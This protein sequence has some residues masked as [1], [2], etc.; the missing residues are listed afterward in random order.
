MIT[1]VYIYGMIVGMQ[2]TIGNGVIKFSLLGFVCQEYCPNFFDALEY[3]VI[4]NATAFG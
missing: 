3:V 2:L 4:V 1:F